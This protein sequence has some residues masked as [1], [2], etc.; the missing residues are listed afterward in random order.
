ME[1]V[2]TFC[3]EY[4]YVVPHNTLYVHQMFN[5]RRK[6]L[7]GVMHLMA[8]SRMEHLALHHGLYKFAGSATLTNMPNDVWLP[9]EL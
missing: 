7:G 5:R 6:E 4:S 9:C 3:Q 2:F 1:S 8:L